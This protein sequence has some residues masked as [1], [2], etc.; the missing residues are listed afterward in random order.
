MKIIGGNL[1]GKQI[2]F[3]KSKITRPLRNFVKEN[4]FNIIQNSQKINMSISN[5]NILD[6]YSGIGSFGIECISRKA[7]KVTFVEN[8]SLAE[9]TLKSNL[10]N[11]NIT[12]KC[13]VFTNKTSIV[14]EKIKNRKFDLIFLDPPFADKLFIQDLSLINRHKIYSDEHLVVIHREK[15]DDFYVN[16]LKI[17][18]TK[19]YGR[20]KIIFAKFI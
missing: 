17:I 2:S 18:M 7:K 14:I 19:K 3:L 5:S 11:L 1:K 10:K 15:T 12:E 20:S 6:L 8:N 16:S 9:K 4:I 13:E